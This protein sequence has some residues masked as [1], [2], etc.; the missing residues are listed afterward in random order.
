MIDKIFEEVEEKE[1]VGK[2]STNKK[3]NRVEKMFKGT[4]RYKRECKK[5][6]QSTTKDETFNCLMVDIPQKS[7][8]TLEECIKFS[9][10]TEEVDCDCNRCR[11]GNENCQCGDSMKCK[12][13]KARQTRKIQIHPEVLLIQI[14]R[15]VDKKGRII[16]M[17]V[18]Q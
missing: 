2:V 16:N 15:F 18:S 4:W 12:S 6:N 11:C 8:V 9:Q 10:R 7:K 14:K 17:L 1:E 13:I 3:E 5:C